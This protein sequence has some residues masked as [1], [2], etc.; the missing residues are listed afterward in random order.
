[1]QNLSNRDDPL[2]LDSG[3]RRNDGRRL[4]VA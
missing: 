3:I 4:T 2:A 1:M